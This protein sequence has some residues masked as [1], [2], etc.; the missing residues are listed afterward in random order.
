MVSNLERYKKDLEKLICEGMQLLQSLDKCRDL[1]KSE[2]SESE[3][4]PDFKMD[5]QVWYTESLAV[6]KQIIPDRK[7]D[8]IDFYEGSEE[9]TKRYSVEYI[10]D[11]LEGS[12]G[13]CDINS[14]ICNFKQQLAILK[15]VQRKFESSLFDIKQLLQADLFD[16]E[17]SAAEELNKKGFFRGAGVI[18]GVVLEKHLLQVCNTHKIE[19]TKKDST[20]NGLAEILKK[21]DIIDTP[22]WRKIQYLADLRNDC[23]HKNEKEPEKEEIVKL[24]KGVDE[25]IKNVF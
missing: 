2:K 4:L 8:F 14:V 13:E 1:S 25:I 15:S 21:K 3:K 12:I 17:L 11:Y 24:I 19:I 20:I 22:K 7:D 18:A 6:I 5:Y 9:K 23:C 16:S 10:K